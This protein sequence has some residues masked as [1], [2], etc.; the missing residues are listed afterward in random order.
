MTDASLSA[1]VERFLA[2]A[3]KLEDDVVNVLGAQYD[4]GLAW[5]HFGRGWGG[6]GATRDMTRQVR[7][8]LREAGI[9]ASRAGFVGLNQAATL[10]HDYGSDEH[11]TRFL[12]RIFTG[13]DQ[14]CQLF[15]EPGAGSDLANVATIAVPDG[16]GWRVS[17]QK[18]W[19]SNA[20]HA[21]FALLLARTD[22]AAPKHRGMSLF[23]VDM[24][25]PGVVV[26]PL[27]QADG[28]ARF[29]EVFLDDVAIT[30][31]FLLGAP[32]QGWSLSMHI[33][34]TERDGAGGV[35]LRRIE[36]VLELW[37]A[38]A[39]LSAPALRDEVIK[40]WIESHVIALSNRRQRT[41]P[42]PREA[43]VLGSLAKVAASEHSQRYSELMSVIIG[44]DILVDADYDVAFAEDANP[45]SAVSKD[46]G[47]LSPHR[48]VI[49]TRAMSIEGGTNE[50]SRNLIGERTLGLAPDIRVD[51]ELPWRDLPKS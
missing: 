8:R 43:A 37:R 21:D 9:P 13:E 27:R 5:P 45:D 18:V 1:V 33:L 29:S 36:D 39:H 10:I 38:R 35:F 46:F 47:S 20:H 19:T 17:G 44:P 42:D 28:G 15:S 22:P 6:L 25:D 23:I 24:S 16:A 14:W 50:I 7:D 3:H 40:L 49:R 48:F 2:D 11:K 30:G 32:G 41:T 12:R 31:D 51:K 34:T 26:R 4:A